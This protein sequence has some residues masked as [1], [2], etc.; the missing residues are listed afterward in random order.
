MEMISLSPEIPALCLSRWVLQRLAIEDQTG[1]RPAYAQQFE[2][3]AQAALQ[4]VNGSS[5][6]DAAALVA[7]ARRY[8]FTASA[9]EAE[10]QAGARA[11]QLGDWPAAREYYRLALAAGLNPDESTKRRI[12]ALDTAQGRDRSTGRSYPRHFI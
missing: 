8:P 7:V 6:P 5:H 11:A 10:R 2:P 1:F 9:V 12:D 3:A 4:A